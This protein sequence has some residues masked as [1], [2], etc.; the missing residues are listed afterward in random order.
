L[1]SGNPFQKLTAAWGEKKISEYPFS[2]SQFSE[3]G[4]RYDLTVPFARYV[5]MHQNEISFPFRRYQIQPVFRADRPQ[6]G[7]YREFYQCDADVIGSD[8]LLNEAELIQIYDEVF[9]ELELPVTI[10]LNNRKILEGMAESMNATEKFKTIT[11]AID[12]LDKIGLQGVRQLLSEN[13]LTESQLQLLEKFF[14]LNG[15]SNEIL[16]QA[17]NLLPNSET[18][19][20]GIQELKEIFDLLHS[21]G[22]TKHDVKLDFTLARG[23]DYY[24]GAII[25]VKPLEAKMGSVGGGGRYD[26]LT[27]VFG[28]KNVSGVGISFGA[29]RIYDVMLEQNLFA[30]QSEFS[31]QVMFACFDKA[32]LHY[33]LPLA[34][35]LRSEGMAV[36]IYPAPDKLKKQM[37]Y[38]GDKS[39]PFVIVIGE[40]EM[41]SG[42]L[43][44]KNMST[45]E[46]SMKTINEVIS[47][48]KS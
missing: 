23:L 1:N 46:Q 24:T 6:R 12:K 39:I 40:E 36:E 28:L 27:G 16:G 35:R 25:E 8:S 11:I 20:K 18:G 3:K 47:Y 9:K 29:D 42:K 10:H 43:S 41:K 31:S 17:L 21:A 13:G 30:E 33:C 2:V 19:L 38:A 37:K 45:G 32:A 15:H 4:L 26:D 22:G 44:V 5:V 48:L 14:S 34:S 7:R